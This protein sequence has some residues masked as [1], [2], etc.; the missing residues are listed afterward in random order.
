M[1]FRLHLLEQ[2]EG[3]VIA[4]ELVN[5]VVEVAFSIVYTHYLERH[6]FPYTVQQARRS[7]LQIIEV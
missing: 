2:E 4:A 3:S 6:S 5:E 1:S 7:L